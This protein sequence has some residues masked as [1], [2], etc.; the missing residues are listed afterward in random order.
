MLVRR[1]ESLSVRLFRRSRNANAAA[2]RAG[3]ALPSAVSGPLLDRIDLH[4][5]VPAVEYRDVASERAEESSGAI[6]ERVSQGA[7]R[8]QERFR[9]GLQDKL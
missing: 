8:Q 6:R 1:D 3:P 7:K 9:T 5:E 2:A 4:I